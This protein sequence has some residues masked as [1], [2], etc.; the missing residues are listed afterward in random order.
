MVSIGA[1]IRARVLWAVFFVLVL[2]PMALGDAG[3]PL[4][5]MGFLRLVFINIVIGVGEGLAIALVFRTGILR[6]IGI[7]LLANYFSWL[8]GEVGLL[9][10]AAVYGERIL[11][12]RPLYHVLAFMKYLIGAALL[13][14]VALEWPLCFWVCRRKKGRIAK[15]I[16]AALGVNLVSYAV[17]VWLYMGVSGTTVLTRLTPEPSLEFAVSKDAWVYYTSSGELALNRIRIDGTGREEVLSGAEMRDRGFREPQHFHYGSKTPLIWLYVKKSENGR[18]DLCCDVYDEQTVLLA[19]FAPSSAKVG[20]VKEDEIPPWFGP[21]FA[22]DLGSSGWEV[23]TGEWAVEGLWAKKG[24][25]EKR[26]GLELPFLN[27]YTSFATVLPGDQVVYQLGNQIV[28]VDLN[29]DKI[30]V[31]TKGYSPVVV[32]EREAPFVRVT[33]SDIQPEEQ[34][35]P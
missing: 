8:V 12:E 11:G 24:N 1:M 32:L 15:S 18:L 19:G 21:Y 5:L 10:L 26:L 20:V 3:T 13:M 4:M 25:M 28:L 16:I 23:W 35:N 6:S 17:L 9:P 31:I 33:D 14:S 30:G 34:G 22:V 2:A 7:M 29:A 27:W